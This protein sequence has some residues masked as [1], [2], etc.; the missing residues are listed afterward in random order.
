MVPKKQGK[1]FSQAKK[2]MYKVNI[3]GLLKDSMSLG[4][5]G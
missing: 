2:D 5:V 4:E 3:L 1:S